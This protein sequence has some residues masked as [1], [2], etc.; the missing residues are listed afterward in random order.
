MLNRGVRRMPVFEDALA[1]RSFMRVLHDGQERTSI[2]LL[3]YCVMPNH[4][5]LIVWPDRDGQMVE[6]MRWFQ[7]VHKKRW[8]QF[9][10]NEGAG[11]LYQGRYK[12][13]P[14]QDDDHFLTVC[15]YVERNPLRAGLVTRAEQLPWS[16]R[17]NVAE[18][19][20]VHL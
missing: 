12:A 15:R 14:V 17:A 3:A 19:A 16:S 5:H 9:R 6:F 20:K 18:T 1:Y 8:H 10:Q 13:F 7:M 2:R 4:F 11:A